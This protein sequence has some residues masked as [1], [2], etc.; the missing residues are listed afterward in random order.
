MK[1]LSLTFLLSA[2]L[3][4]LAACGGEETNVKENDVATNDTS[5][6]SGESKEESKDDVYFKNGEVKLN[7]LQIKITETKVIPVGEPGNEYGEN[8]VFA[9]WYDTTNLSDKDIDPTTAWAAV[10]TAIQDNDPN[11]INQLEVGMLPDD[12]HLDTQ[13]ETIKKGGT[14]SNSIAYELDDLETPVTLVATQ[15]LMGEELGKQNYNI[16]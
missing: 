3:V 10:F 2:L 15:G 4:L 9:I 12:S 5:N 14:V 8:P 16:K 1:K 7:D 13:L 11:A 6:A